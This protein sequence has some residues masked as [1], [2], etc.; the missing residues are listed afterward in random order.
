MLTHPFKFGIWVSITL[1]GLAHAHIGAFH[2]AMFC[3]N[4]TDPTAN[5]NNNNAPVSP[6]FNLTYQDFWFHHVNGCDELPPAPGDFLE[7]PAG[8][9]FTVELA[10]NRA[11]TSLNPDAV[12][13]DWGDGKDH[14]DP[15]SV[16]NLG[17]YPLSDSHCLSTPNLHTQNESMAAGTA[18]A[19][20]YESELS[21]V[22]PETLVVF[23]V[24]YHTPFKRVVT[25]DVPSGMPLCPD[26]GC[27]CSIPNGCGEPNMYMFPYRCK[28]IP[29]STPPMTIGAPKPPVWCEDDTSKC[30]QGPKQMLIWNQQERNNIEVQGNDMS[31]HPKSPGYNMKCGFQDGGCCSDVP[32][33]PSL[34]FRVCDDGLGDEYDVSIGAQKDLSASTQPAGSGTPALPSMTPTTSL[35]AGSGTPTNSDPPAGSS[36][37]SG[38]SASCKRSFEDTTGAGHAT[39]SKRMIMHREKKNIF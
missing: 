20:A 15:Y 37:P 5:P 39:H 21:K 28:V 22:T 27:I 34:S 16:N 32:P 33:S 9:N 25:Y 29:D 12:L 6:L 19:I 13:T 26:Q 24:R 1:A 10:E 3:I 30:V 18:F 7:L 17:G 36:T 38:S 23:S 4:G 11:F 2:Q 14:S 35:P 31:G 8:G